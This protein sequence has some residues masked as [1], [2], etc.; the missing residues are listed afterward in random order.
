MSTHTF[1]EYDKGFLAG[2]AARQVNDEVE[3]IDQDATLARVNGELFEALE[4]KW[5]Y[6]GLALIFAATTLAAIVA[7]IL[8]GR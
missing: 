5:F 4:A 3:H 7:W 8:W 2:I 6:G 1:T